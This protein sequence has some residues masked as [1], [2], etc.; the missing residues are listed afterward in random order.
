MLQPSHIIVAQSLE[1]LVEE[2]LDSLR[3][4]VWAKSRETMR[5]SSKRCRTCPESG[6]AEEACSM[7]HRAETSDEHQMVE[8]HVKRTFLTLP[9]MTRAA[10]SVAQ[11]TTEANLRNGIN[12]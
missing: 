4:R 1:Y 3:K 11:S 8:L 5:G 7:A 12:P 9:K 2:A 6:D 10:A